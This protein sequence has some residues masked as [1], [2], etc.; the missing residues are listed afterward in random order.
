M[1]I[2][3]KRVGVDSRNNSGVKSKGGGGQGGGGIWGG[4][5]E[6]DQLRLL[7]DRLVL[8]RRHISLGAGSGRPRSCPPSLDAARG[9]NL[10]LIINHT[11]HFSSLLWEGREAWTYFKAESVFFNINTGSCDAADEGKSHRKSLF[12]LFFLLFLKVF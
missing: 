9:F 10:V 12:F 8:L 4:I 1:K 5:Y 6:L 11:K 2:T 7:W 3:L